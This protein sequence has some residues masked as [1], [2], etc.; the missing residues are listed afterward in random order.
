MEMKIMCP[1]PSDSEEMVS[2]SS[3]ERNKCITNSVSE[4]FPFGPAFRLR[5][6]R[7]RSYRGKTKAC[8]MTHALFFLAR[9]QIKWSPIAVHQRESYPARRI[10]CNRVDSYQDSAEIKKRAYIRKITPVFI[11]IQLCQSLKD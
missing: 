8:H 10:E 9:S 7:S 4:R 6:L 2:G 11:H 3:H 5:L 1:S